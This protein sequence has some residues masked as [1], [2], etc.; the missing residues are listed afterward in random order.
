MS[1]S[2]SWAA[3]PS[4]TVTVARDIEFYL[5]LI[6]FQV[7]KKELKLCSYL[8]L[9]NI[10]RQVGDCLFRVPRRPF[11]EKS[12]IFSDMFGLPL[13][14]QGQ[15]NYNVCSDEEPLRL[16][17]IKQQDFRSFL[18]VLLRNERCI[19]SLSSPADSKM[20]FDEW[21][22][23]LRL[24]K[25][26]EFEEEKRKALSA[27][28]G[29]LD[30]W[31]LFRKLSIACEFDIKEWFQPICEEITART[32][33]PRPEEV[34]GLD[35]D[36]LHAIGRARETHYKAILYW[37]MIDFFKPKCSCKGTLAANK[38]L[39]ASGRDWYFKCEKCASVFTLED[40][41][42]MTPQLREN[43]AKN[44]KECTFYVA[45][46]ILVWRL[47]RSNPFEGATRKKDT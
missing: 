29:M 2:E 7:R 15:D 33:A 31:T 36:F 4:G 3:G 9:R 40:A 23:A 34:T 22:G 39:V 11:E 44:V 10:T 43:T 16:V 21:I 25:M 46:N 35:P 19:D 47:E 6:T 12:S 45:L 14:G 32:T 1:A 37:I 28:E 38:N 27:L 42:Q 24:A 17:G 5:A 8:K 26:W 30:N 41:I 20:S 18:R 13:V